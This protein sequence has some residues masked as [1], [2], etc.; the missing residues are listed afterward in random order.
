MSSHVRKLRRESHGTKAIVKKLFFGI[1]TS[2][3]MNTNPAIGQTN[4]VSC[5]IENGV[6]KYSDG[7]TTTSLRLDIDNVQSNPRQMYRNRN[8]TAVLENDRLV[9]VIGGERAMEGHTILG[10]L[11]GTITLSNS[12][13]IPLDEP[14][15]RI[16]KDVVLGQNDVLTI[17]VADGQYIVN[18]NNPFVW[19][20]R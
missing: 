9:V 11:N 14:R 4:R 1:L 7:R 12:Y 2:G 3:I 17:T 13:M 6:V 19:I 15:R 18:L 5:A 8:F 16:I 20:V 10:D